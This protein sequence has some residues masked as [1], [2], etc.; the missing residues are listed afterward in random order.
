MV[1]VDGLKATNDMRTGTKPG[2]GCSRSWQM[3]SGDSTLSSAGMQATSSQSSFQALAARLLSVT[4]ATSLH[5]L[6][7]PICETRP[8]DLAYVFRPAWESQSS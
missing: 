5:P 7:R 1:D 4:S 6:G 2:I 3:L 8:R